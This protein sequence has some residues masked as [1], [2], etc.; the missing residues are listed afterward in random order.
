MTPKFEFRV[1]AV[2][3]ALEAKLNE[4]G[5]DG[6]QLVASYVEASGLTMIVLQREVFASPSRR[7]G[8]QQG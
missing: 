6:W 8:R 3:D 5:A 4:Y 2:S 1:I 7:A